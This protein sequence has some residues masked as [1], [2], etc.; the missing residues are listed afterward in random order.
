MS[1]RYELAQKTNA[2]LQRLLGT[3]V[4]TV[5]NARPLLPGEISRTEAINRILATKGF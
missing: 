2:E 3:A 5:V 1:K 4:P